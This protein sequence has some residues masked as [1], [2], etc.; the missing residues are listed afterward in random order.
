MTV[1]RY[2]KRIFG[3]SNLMLHSKCPLLGEGS[4]ESTAKQLEWTKWVL[5][6]IKIGKCHLL[7]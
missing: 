7:R 6:C 2:F 1:K 3:F 5:N 4:K